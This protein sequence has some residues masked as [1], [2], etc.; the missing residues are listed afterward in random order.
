M[1]RMGAISLSKKDKIN[2]SARI[3]DIEINFVWQCSAYFKS[4]VRC[5]VINL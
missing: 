1:E 2:A 3:A 4:C 5:C